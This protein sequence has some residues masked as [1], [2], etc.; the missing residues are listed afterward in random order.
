MQ[1][2][3]IAPIYTAHASAPGRMSNAGKL[4]LYTVNIFSENQPSA[5]ILITKQPRYFNNK[6]APKGQGDRIERRID[7]AQK[8]RTS[9]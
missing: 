8:R 6:T 4:L 9:L 1:T 3:L 2:A 7:K 5:G